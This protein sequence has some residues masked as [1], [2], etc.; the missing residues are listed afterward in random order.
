MGN[1][2]QSDVP[3]LAYIKYLGLCASALLL[4][5]FV[6][7]TCGPPPVSEPDGGSIVT[8]EGEAIKPPTGWGKTP[9]P[10]GQTCGSFQWGDVDCAAGLVCAKVGGGA[11]GICL[12]S[13]TAT[14]GTCDNNV[15]CQEVVTGTWACLTKEPLTALGEECGT[16]PCQPPY[17]CIK[18]RYESASRCRKPCDPAPG[19]PNDCGDGFLYGY[20]PDGGGACIP[21][22][23]GT[24]D[25]FGKCSADDGLCKTSP[26]VLKCVTESSRQPSWGSCLR[27]CDDSLPCPEG[28][29]CIPG[30][31]ACAKSC[32]VKAK[33]CE[34]GTCQPLENDSTQ[35]VCY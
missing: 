23:P 17:V 28:L 22:P 2:Y 12:R 13:C 18:A 7:C 1:S 30:I 32:D 27:P 33:D 14:T 15:P 31:N 5:L 3:L 20:M 25:E 8:P 11:Q 16:K 34:Y 4:A 10:L 29:T 9:M 6:S 24:V 35:G 26:I 19:V 21:L